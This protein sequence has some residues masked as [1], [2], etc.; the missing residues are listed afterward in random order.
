MPAICRGLLGED[1]EG[2][3]GERTTTSM[4][5]DS[6]S[7]IGKDQYKAYTDIGRTWLQGGII[8][9]STDTQHQQASPR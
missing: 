7:M 2:T 3:A 8:S 4:G 5:R 1:G 9:T 6:G